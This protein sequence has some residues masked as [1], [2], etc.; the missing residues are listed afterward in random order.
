[1]RTLTVGDSDFF[2]VADSTTTD[3]FMNHFY[4]TG[5]SFGPRPLRLAVPSPS[6]IR[7]GSLL[8]TCLMRGVMVTMNLRLDFARC[9]TLN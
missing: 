3:R 7:K 6:D 8:T 2:I 5:A 9:N 1:M 4:P